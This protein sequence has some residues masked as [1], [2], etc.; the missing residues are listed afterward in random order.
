MWFPW[1]FSQSLYLTSY[2]V[3]LLLMWLC[4]LFFCEKSAVSRIAVSMMWSV[5]FLWLY[6][7]LLC[8]LQSGLDLFLSYFGFVGLLEC[9]D[10][11]PSLGLEKFSAILSSN[12]DS[13]P[14]IFIFI[15]P[16]SHTIIK[17]VVDFLIVSSSSFFSHLFFFLFFPILHTEGLYAS[18]WTLSPR[19]STF[20][21]DTFIELVFFTSINSFSQ[22]AMS[23]FIGFSSLRYFQVNNLFLFKWYT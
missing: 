18:S 12:I 10:W 15:F 23:L 9:V 16:L 6:F 22:Y 20:L 14:L 5:T 4:N 19:M 2:E 8:F 17:S 1:T 13:A 3:G 11:F 7:L 21:P